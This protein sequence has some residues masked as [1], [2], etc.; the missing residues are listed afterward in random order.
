VR[1]SAGLITALHSLLLATPQPVGGQPVSGLGPLEPGHRVRVWHS[2]PC[3]RSPLTGTLVSVSGDS[4]VLRAAEA[5][6]PRAISR[7]FVRSVQRAYT[8]GDYGMRGMGLG[9]LAGLGTGAVVGHLASSCGDIPDGCFTI[10]GA[11][12]GGVLGGFV[13]LVVGYAVGRAIPRQDWERVGLP[14]R[15]GIA[16]PATR[17]DRVS[18]RFTLRL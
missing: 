16:D 18:V 14:S 5:A 17:R 12:V 11:A 15:V 3:C 1:Y 13:G 2:D 7:T 9:A 8:A 4:V 6:P 10:F